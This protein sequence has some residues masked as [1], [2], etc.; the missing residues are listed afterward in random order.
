[1]FINFKFKRKMDETA[2]KISSPDNQ[3]SHKLSEKFDNL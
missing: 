3:I 1:M 2:K